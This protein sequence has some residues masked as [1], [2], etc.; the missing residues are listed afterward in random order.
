[1]A[2]LNDLQSGIVRYVDNELMPK[3]PQSG[4]EKI[5]VGTA[6]GLILKRNFSK[7]ESFKDHPIVKL[8]GIVD[9]EGNIDLDTLATEV[10]NNMPQTGISVE[11]PMIGKMTFKSEDIDKLKQYIEGSN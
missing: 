2:T 1:M 9:D 7:I 3:L 8:T 4:L 5:V 10:K 6:L 11:A